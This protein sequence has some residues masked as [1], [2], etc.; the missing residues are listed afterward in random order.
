M[1]AFTFRYG[2]TSFG[3]FSRLLARSLGCFNCFSCFNLSVVHHTWSCHVWRRG[4]C[5]PPAE[6]RSWPAAAWRPFAQGWF[7]EDSQAL[8]RKMLPPFIHHDFPSLS[9]GQVAYLFG[10]L[11]R[12]PEAEWARRFPARLML[13]SVEDLLVSSALLLS[14]FSPPWACV[15]VQPFFF[16][17]R[18]GRHHHTDYPF[19]LINDRQRD[20]VFRPNDF[21]RVRNLSKGVCDGCRENPHS[22]FLTFVTHRA[23]LGFSPSQLRVPGATGLRIQ[24]DVGSP[25]LQ[26]NLPEEARE[27]VRAW[28]SQQPP[29]ASL[30]FILSA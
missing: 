7:F 25:V 22:V 19:P 14:T 8:S 16:S 23:A 9:P 29:T 11:V 26:L 6:P 12:G 21:P 17:R 2:G 3:P 24:P 4:K 28:V 18:I 15:L 20:P 13:R 27:T 1:M 30:P 10:L 5:G